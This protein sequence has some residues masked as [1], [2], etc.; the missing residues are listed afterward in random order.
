MGFS[1]NNG[2]HN[3]LDYTQF[4]PHP[5]SSEV[6]GKYDGMLV[7]VLT[8]RCILPAMRMLVGTEMSGSG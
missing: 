7:E 6:G 5:K 8:A 2:I 4:V 3:G 1:A